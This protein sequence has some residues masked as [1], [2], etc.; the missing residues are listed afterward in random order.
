MAIFLSSILI[1]SW[2]TIYVYWC[3]LWDKENIKA[4]FRAG[5]CAVGI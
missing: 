4:W 2:F 1:V 5:V 3:V